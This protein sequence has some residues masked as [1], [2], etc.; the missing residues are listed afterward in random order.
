MY[1][2]LYLPLHKIFENAGFHWPVFSHILCSVHYSFQDGIFKRISII[3][4]RKSAFL[5]YILVAALLFSHPLVTE[6][7]WQQRISILCNFWQYRMCNVKEKRMLSQLN[8]FYQ[9]WR[10]AYL[11]GVFIKVIIDLKWSWLKWIV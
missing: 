2:V 10:D 7:N 1:S 9:A 4:S 6:I 5:I 3:A 11:A 8:S